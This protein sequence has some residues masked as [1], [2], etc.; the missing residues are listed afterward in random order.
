MKG[1]TFLKGCT[2]IKVLLL[3]PSRHRIILLKQELVA[4]AHCPLPGGSDKKVKCFIST[5]YLSIEILFEVLQLSALHQDSSSICPR[6]VGGDPHQFVWST[7][8]TTKQ[9]W[10]KKMLKCPKRWF[11]PT[12]GVWST[13]LLIKIHNNENVCVCLCVCV[14]VC[15]CVTHKDVISARIFALNGNPTGCTCYESHPY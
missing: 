9:F 3:N 11:G 15:V 12:N 6:K 1:G 14:C 4:I 13:S 8:I 7:Q 10:W 2:C 5:C